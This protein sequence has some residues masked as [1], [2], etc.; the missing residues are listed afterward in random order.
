[1]TRAQNCGALTWRERRAG[2]PDAHGT[3]RGG[4]HA[5][6]GGT[7]RAIFFLEEN[8]RPLGMRGARDRHGGV[9]Q[10]GASG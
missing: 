5:R 7:V 4:V 1:M 3:A 10:W 6:G 8:A 9:L 2:T